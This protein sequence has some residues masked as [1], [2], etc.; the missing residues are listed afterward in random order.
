MIQMKIMALPVFDIF[1]CFSFEGVGGH[2][3]IGV[4]D[5]V[6]VVVEACSSYSFVNWMSSEVFVIKVL[7]FP[8]NRGLVYRKG[9]CFNASPLGGK[10]FPKHFTKNQF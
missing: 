8:S 5:S 4:F 6:R 7:L 10:A 2:Q 9:F 1:S 3:S